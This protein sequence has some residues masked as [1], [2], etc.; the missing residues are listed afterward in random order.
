MENY[1]RNYWINF[2]EKKKKQYGKIA[3]ENPLGIP[4]RI[5]GKFQ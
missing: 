2:R 4:E 1:Q 3:K 5:P